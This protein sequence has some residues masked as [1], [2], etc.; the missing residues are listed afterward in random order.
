METLAVIKKYFSELTP[1]KSVG[2]LEL[3]KPFSRYVCGYEFKEDS[4]LSDYDDNIT[5]Y[6][7]Y[8]QDSDSLYDDLT[9]G[10]DNGIVYGIS[11]HSFL[12]YEGINIVGTKIESVILLLKNHDYWEEN[13]EIIDELMQIY[14]FDSLGLMLWVNHGVIDCIDCFGEDE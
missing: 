10:V 14:H 2:F 11:C 13:V 7:F 5:V 4:E 8:D 1:F 3:N 9:I 12:F 6:K